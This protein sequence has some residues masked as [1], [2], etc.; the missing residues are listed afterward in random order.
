M[1]KYRK[2]KKQRANRRIPVKTMQSETELYITIQFIMHFES[3]NINVQGRRMKNQEWERIEWAG[4]IRIDK[5]LVII[6]EK[7]YEKKR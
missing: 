6:S 1:I 5:T 4:Q 7:I 2:S 3:I